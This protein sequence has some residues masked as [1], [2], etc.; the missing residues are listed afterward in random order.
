MKCWSISNDAELLKLLKEG[1]INSA[2]I[3]AKTIESV[4]AKHFP[5]FPY[6]NYCVLYQKKVLKVR[7]GENIDRKETRTSNQ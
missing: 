4:Y 7:T 5:E 6:R 2:G 3:A 1:K